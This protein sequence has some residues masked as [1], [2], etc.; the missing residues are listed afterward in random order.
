MRE[1]WRWFGPQDPISLSD[2]RQAGATG[3]VTALHDLPNGTIWPVE[4]IRQRQQMIAA[5]GLD[6]QVVE[7]VPVHEDIKTATPGWQRHAEAWAQTLVN[8]AQCG[9]RTVCYNFMPVLDWT[10]TDLSFALPDGARC[11]R[12]DHVDMALF[13]L[14]ILE[15]PGACADYDGPIREAAQRRFAAISA[16]DADKLTQTIIAGLP[17]AEESFSLDQFRKQL[18][19]YFGFDAKRLRANLWAFL[20]IVVPVAETH[21]VRLALHPDDP[22]RSLFGLPRIV[23]TGADLAAVL[24][25]VDSPSNGLTFCTGSL[26]VRADNDLPALLRQYGDRV[27]FLHLRATRREADGMSFHEASHLNGDIDMVAIIEEVLRIEKA[28]NQ[29]LPFRPDH[30]HALADDQRRSGNPGY[31]LIGRLR[32]LAEIRGVVH[33][34]RRQMPS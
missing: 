8:L 29:E 19:R 11:L 9:I 30:G 24:A 14:H 26:G 32:G 22:P 21:G 18:S 6:W 5:A 33:A 23:S 28:R 17:G 2:I 15:R 16:H 4:L 34:L 20:Q 10:R 1:T 3:I 25:M 31:P 27:H 13:D 7:S 12:F